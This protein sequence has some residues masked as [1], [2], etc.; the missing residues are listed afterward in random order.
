MKFA[1][2]FKQVWIVQESAVPGRFII[3]VK[4]AESENIKNRLISLDGQ[5]IGS[6]RIVY[7]YSFLHVQ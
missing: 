7:G 2:C 4:R 3:Q 5:Q 1:I 6:R